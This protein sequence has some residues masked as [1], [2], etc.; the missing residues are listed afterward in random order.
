MSKIII[1]QEKIKDYRDEFARNSCVFIPELIEK[2]FLK[3]FLPKI[4]KSIFNEKEEAGDYK[5]GKVLFVPLTEPSVFILHVLL[6]DKVFFQALQQIT[7][8]PTIKDFVGRIHR[9]EGKQHEINWHGDNSDN[10]LLA[11]SLGLGMDR[12]EGAQF[13]LRE[14]ESKKMLAEYGQLEAGDAILFKISP[15]LEHRLA[16]IEKGRRTVGVGWFRS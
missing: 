11:I 9:S 16:P 10:R 1:Q 7:H 4:E 3:T 8:C 13:Q 15:E 5:F 14:K 6:N 12:Y 2:N